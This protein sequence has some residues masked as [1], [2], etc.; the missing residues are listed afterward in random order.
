MSIGERPTALQ[1]W[2]SQAPVWGLIA[3]LA[4][5]SLVVWAM[6][7]WELPAPSDDLK[8]PWWLVAI[9]FAAVESF[10]INLH[11]RSE[12]GSFSLLEIPLVFGLLFTEPSLLWL[13]IVV[14]SAISLVAIRKQPWVKVAFNVANLSLH[15]GVAAVLFA[16]LLDG[17]N[18][19]EPRGWVALFGAT[20]IS[21]LVEVLGIG[22]VIRIT[23]RRF[24][25]R[26]A[27]N[28]VV[29]GWLVATANSL[30]ALIA[31]LVIVVEPWGGLLLVGS[32][33]M[34]F[35]AYKAYVSERDHRERVEFL[36]HSTRSLRESQEMNEAV[37]ILLEEAASMFRA[38]TI[39]LLVFPAPDSP[40]QT[41]RFLFHDNATS[42]VEAESHSEDLEAVI[43]LAELPFLALE[44]SSPALVR[45]HLD[46]LGVRDAM[47]GTLRS[48]QRA[49]GLL[50]VGDRLGN[51]TT[52]TEEDLRLFENLVDQAAVALENDQ[53]EQALS[54]LRE[55]ES[56][57]S[58]QARYDVLTG[59]ANRNLFSDRLED[60]LGSDTG[61]AITLLYIDLDDFKLVNDRLGHAAGDALLVE[62]ASRVNGVIRP[63]D[64]AARLGGDEFAV[65]MNGAEEAE[66]VA[67][68]IIGTLSAP[69][70]L[71]PDE[72][73][74]G[75]SVG[76]ATNQG[77]ALAAD[78]LHQADLA[79]YG[80]KERGK[81]SVV[82]YSTGL[83]SDQS[84]QQALQT[85]LRRAI[86]EEEFEVV[87]QPIVKLND[88][89]VV[90][91][92]ALVRWRREDGTPLTPAH[93]IAEAERSGLIMSIDR[94]VRLTVLGEL[95]EM[96]ETAAD[97][98][99]LSLNLSARHLQQPEFV[100]E[101]AGDLVAHGA[102]ASSL[103]LEVTESAF[104]GDAA[105][106]SGVLTDIRSLGVRI[107]LD[108][109]GTGYSSLSYLRDLPIDFLK[110]A[111]PF[112]EDL[113]APNGASFVD[114][115]TSLGRTL[116]LT[117]I[118]EGIER[119][120]ELEVL[121]SVQCE[122]GQGFHF[123]RPMPRADLIRLIESDARITAGSRLRG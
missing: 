65:M 92:E 88:L 15:V 29:F 31:V 9:A 68:R 79:M 4:T 89:S 119:A 12:S 10:V 106:A 118:A 16:W 99:F 34:L 108:D 94:L 86:S 14:G 18:P 83:Q 117:V 48:D 43:M 57:L 85:A 122:L 7:L 113:T 66:P 26:R 59:L 67:H 45:A 24:E 63:D 91:A 11:F 25:A 21:S 107:A 121:R 93:F 35:V 75:A 110:I 39:E 44:N 115:I 5:M 42:C 53:L 111:Q 72:V 87:Y 61:A 97:S 56:E 40:D 100:D 74:I 114:A 32:T 55:L 50:V 27:W 103:V 96:L 82:W 13:A 73:R 116:S 64:L 49:V 41:T 8:V 23:E 109:F 60:R 101:F 69:F 3:S 78:L 33:A 22:L 54:R 46:R 30:Q 28:M 58:H 47:I 123:A 17:T 36:Y 77:D 98:F 62:V 120:E 102:S 80:A 104:V 71:G 95:D 76:I 112:V 90:G 84:R 1:Q 6:R 38:S 70:L 81:G 37:S 20:I 2:R 51:V 105:T 19:M 52:F